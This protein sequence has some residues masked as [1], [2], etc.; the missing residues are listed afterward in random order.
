MKNIL[1]VTNDV[2][3]SLGMQNFENINNLEYQKYYKDKSGS[4]H[5][6][7]LSYI[8]DSFENQIFVD[9]GT[10]KGCSA[11]ALSTNPK[12]KVYSFNLIEQKELKSSPDN[13]EFILD[14]VVNGNYDD[15]LEKSKLILLDTNHDGSFE[16][17]F[18]NY[19]ISKNFKVVVMYDDI[20]LN[21]AMI[22]FWNS[23]NL[24]KENIT[25]IGHST[26]TGVVY[27]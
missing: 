21:K 10:L 27:Y 23:I 3:D 6:R 25:S 17:H 5:Y 7:L 1:K 8:S 26:G 13:C 18:H 11:L 12:N 24:E 19:L 15:L 2:L 4:E 20:F 16:N 14:D 22:E 9:I